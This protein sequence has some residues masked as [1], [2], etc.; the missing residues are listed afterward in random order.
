[1]PITTAAAA[2]ISAGTQLVGAAASFAQAAKNNRLKREAETAAKKY[3]E[4]AVKAYKTNY[5]EDIQVP[6]EGYE[7]AAEMNT[8]AAAQSL[9]A[10]RESGQRAV[11]GGVAGLQ[12]QAQQGSE[13]LRMAMQQDL[14]NRNLQIAEEEANIR[15]RLATIDLNQATGAQEAAADAQAMKAKSVESGFGNIAG[16][17]ST[18]YEASEL[19]RKDEEAKNGVGSILP[20]IFRGGSGKKS[21]AASVGGT[22][23]YS[24]MSNPAAGVGKPKIKLP[25]GF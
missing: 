12:Q 10:M 7:R 23:P 25:T 24:R 19:Y 20:G 11:I 6:L 1:M 13:A 9:E 22:A 16:A 5:A 4:D 3:M 8:Q 14:Y 21:S 2:A 15:D 17:G 18:I